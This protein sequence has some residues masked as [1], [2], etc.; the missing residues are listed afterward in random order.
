MTV[1][2]LMHE[3]MMHIETGGMNDEVVIEAFDGKDWGE[4]WIDSISTLTSGKFILG[5][6][7]E[8]D[9]DEQQG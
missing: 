7:N 8:V 9:H 5:I 2:G 4:W 1:M 3:L 6:D